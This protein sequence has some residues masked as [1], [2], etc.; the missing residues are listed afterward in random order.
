MIN[1][2]DKAAKIIPWEKEQPLQQMVKNWIC[3]K[4]GGK[5]MK[6]DPYLLPYTKIKN[7]SKTQI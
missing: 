2:V 4:I 6:A 5:K 7:G 3:T 1:Y